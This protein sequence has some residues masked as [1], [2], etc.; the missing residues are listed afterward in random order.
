MRAYA[1]RFD[2]EFERLDREL[3]QIQIELNSRR[4]SPLSE[5]VACYSHHLDVALDAYFTTAFDRLWVDQIHSSPLN[6]MLRIVSTEEC[7]QC[8]IN[9]E[10]LASVQPMI[11]WSSQVT[12]PNNP[13]DSGDFTIV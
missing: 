5:Q 1:Q 2:E 7:Q 9:C 6:E 12:V 10:A 3:D 4:L 8:A 11:D 13:E